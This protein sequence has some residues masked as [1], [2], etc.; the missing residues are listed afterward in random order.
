MVGVLA[1]QRDRLKAR[2]AEV[3]GEAAAAAQGLA[4]CR[5]D[6][7]AAKA[8]NVALVEQLRFVQGYAGGARPAGADLEAG[9]AGVVGKYSTDYEEIVDPFN[10]FRAKEREARRRRMPL[11][12]RAAF[13]VGSALV[14]GNKVARSAIV[15]YALALH[16]VAF[17]VLVGFSHHQEGKIERL[18]ELCAKVHPLA[19]GAGGVAGGEQDAHVDPVMGGAVAA[20][21]AAGA[22]GRTLLQ[23]WRG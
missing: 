7:A 21:A 5:A 2:L 1:A 8:D 15:V 17:L 20:A 16:F 13:A 18:E 14:S 19:A 10:D 12:D 22:A 3:E 23:H 11:Q 4:R 9:G 6:A